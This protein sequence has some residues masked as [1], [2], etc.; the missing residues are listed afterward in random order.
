MTTDKH[1]CGRKKMFD[2]R[3]FAFGANEFESLEYI[4]M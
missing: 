1:A 3:D 4:I 2:N